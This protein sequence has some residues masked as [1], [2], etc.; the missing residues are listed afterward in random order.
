MDLRVSLRFDHQLLAVE[1]EH[2]V[3][4]ML[5]LTAPPAPAKERLP[6][7][8][9]LVLDRSGS[10]HGDKLEAAKACAGFLARR[11]QP[12]DQ[13]AVIGYDD[14]VTL[15][16]GLKSVEHP[17]AT[18]A[19]IRTIF[20]G[21]STNLSG[22]WLKGA[23]QLRAVPGGRG[24]RKV[25]LLTDGLANVG[26]TEPD[27]LVALTRQAADDGIGTT[28][29]GFG[30]DFDEDL[31]T[32]MADAGGGNSYFAAGPDE[33]PGIFAQEFEG[34]ATLVA[35]NLSVELRPT[36]EVQ[37]LGVLNEYPQT[38]VAGGVQVAMGDAYGQ[39]RRRLVFELF[40]PSLPTLGVATVAEVVV[41]YVAVGPQIAAHE[42]TL[43]VTV[44]LVSAD[45]ATEVDTEVTEEVVILKAARAQDEA[46]RR[47]ERG[48]LEEAKRLLERA[49]SELRGAASGSSRSDELLLQAKQAEHHAAE[50]AGGGLDALSLKQMKFQSYQRQRGRPR[51]EP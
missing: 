7:H 19:A 23:E 1:R 35:Q 44:H 36:P 12:T 25:L 27:Q 4:C 26:I 18:E 14:E 49:A 20:P 43:P 16:A 5:E 50:M 40:I 45:E 9:A 6:L 47:A 11:M 31:L 2:H 28:T 34:L 42:L 30:T 37:V 10:M 46:R 15:Y 32:A 17:E 39:E 3:H 48:E 51:S 24:P 22:G 8:L 29:I 41:R 33:A 21:G 38:Q 13:L